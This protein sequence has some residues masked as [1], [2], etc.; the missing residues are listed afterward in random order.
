MPLFWPDPGGANFRCCS[1]S[2]LAGMM[3]ATAAWSLSFQPLRT[4]LAPRIIPLSKL[5]LGGQP[6][7]DLVVAPP[8][9]SS[10]PVSDA[11][12]ISSDS[13]P[14]WVRSS[15]SGFP[16]SAE[17]VRTNLHAGVPYLEITGCEPVLELAHEGDQIGL[18]LGGQPEPQDQVEELHR[19]LERE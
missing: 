7:G 14:G 12:P 11:S 4:S 18:L 5:G 2:M 9:P 1:P 6:V 8:W 10:H 13:T 19:V 17:L 16:A 15:S 3:L